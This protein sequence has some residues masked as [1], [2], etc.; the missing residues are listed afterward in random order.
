M[1]FELFSMATPA[2]SCSDINFDILMFGPVAKWREVAP[3]GAPQRTLA[4]RLVTN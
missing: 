3:N 4:K 2:D 1:A